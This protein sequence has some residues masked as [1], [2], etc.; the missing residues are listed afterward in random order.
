MEPRA[1][2]LA[3]REHLTDAR[4]ALERGDYTRALAAVDAALAVDPHYLAAQ[5]LKDRIEREPREVRPVS[6]RLGRSFEVGDQPAPEV[7]NRSGVDAPATSEAPPPPPRAAAAPFADAE[8]AA[9][10]GGWARFEQR[11]RERR[12]ERRVAAAQGALHKRQF[13]GAR[14]ILEEI[15]EIDPGHPAVASFE[16]ELDAWE[17][18]ARPR[19]SWLWPSLAAAAVLGSVW[20]GARYAGPQR[21]A[22]AVSTPAYTAS[23]SIASPS[24]AASSAVAVVPAPGRPPEPGAL[25]TDGSA[26]VPSGTS[27]ATPPIGGVDITGPAARGS[28]QWPMSS[29]I[30]APAR[31]VSPPEPE[32]FNPVSTGGRVDLPPRL[33]WPPAPA[34]AAP[35]LSPTVAPAVLPGAPSPEREAP[36]A[37]RPEPKPDAP[38]APAVPGAA[39]LPRDEDLVR[40]TL[41]RYR[42]AYDSLDARSAQAVWPAVDEGA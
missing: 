6:P 22:V 27:A 8:P 35:P 38:P 30:E 18:R 26:A 9:V 29:A 14:A 31:L 1:R 40:Q 2:R 13:S 11:A 42:A 19:S 5:A 7:P 41:Q 37:A 10:S 15:R 33:V 21:P 28:L 32:P 34:P 23:P 39:P 4:A 16:I 36:V 25:A 3:L 12:I 20:L 24:D 17:Q